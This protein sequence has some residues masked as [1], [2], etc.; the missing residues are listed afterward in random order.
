MGEGNVYA[1]LPTQ[2]V[3]QWLLGSKP[4]LASPTWAFGPRISM[5]TP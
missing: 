4:C 5:F 3:N 1:I 2:R